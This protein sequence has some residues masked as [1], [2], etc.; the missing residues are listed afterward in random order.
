MGTL[1]CL[2]DEYKHGRV[3]A[4]RGE[5]ACFA[6]CAWSTSTWFGLG[7]ELGSGLG[8]GLRLGI[9]IGSRLWSGLGLGLGIGLGLGLP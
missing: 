5:S 6:S 8:S 9:G 1:I 2:L 3:D 7:L 4:W